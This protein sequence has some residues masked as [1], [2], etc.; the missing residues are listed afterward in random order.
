MELGR[1]LLGRLREKV[2]ELI[3]GGLR[4]RLSSSYELTLILLEGDGQKRQ[5]GQGDQTA[6]Q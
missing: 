2:R 6:D 4:A 1:L 3:G 5:E